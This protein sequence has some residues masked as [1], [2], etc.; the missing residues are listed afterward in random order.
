MRNIE[1]WGPPCKVT[2]RIVWWMHWLKPESW[3]LRNK[4][5]LQA[6]SRRTKLQNTVCL[7]IQCMWKV[8]ANTT[9]DECP[10]IWSINL[11]QRR[12][13]KFYQLRR[14]ELLLRTPYGP[15]YLYLIAKQMKCG[16][17]DRALCS[18]FVQKH[19]YLHWKRVHFSLCPFENAV[20]T[21]KDLAP[22]QQEMKRGSMKNVFPFKPVSYWDL[23]SRFFTCPFNGC[24]FLSWLS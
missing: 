7:S 2:M 17:S 4:L 24:F 22:Y 1:E 8:R 15:I 12:S 20:T 5:K 11:F 6:L 19:A 23:L 10:K 21:S 14:Q 18:I 13:R 9:V 3:R 16:F